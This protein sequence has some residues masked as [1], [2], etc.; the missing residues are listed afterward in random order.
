MFFIANV[1]CSQDLRTLRKV[2]ID[3]ILATDMA[4]H[5]TLCKKLDLVLASSELTPTFSEPSIAELPAC[6]PAAQTQ[7]RW[8]ETSLA[9]MSAQVTDNALFDVNKP[10][11][12]QLL[13]ATLIHAADL[14]GQVYSSS[15]LAQQW[16]LRIS[17]EFQA[18]ALKEASLNMPVAP[19]MTNL[20]DIV[21]RAR[22][23][24]CRFSI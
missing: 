24:V 11:D 14:S 13:C 9:A 4:E 7:L 3:A 16:E 18:Q 2:I 23:Q 12:R 15:E 19:F 21:H 20:D 5:F 17:L 8:S 1:D 22:M 10:D 6:N